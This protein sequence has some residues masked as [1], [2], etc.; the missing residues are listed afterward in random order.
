MVEDLDRAIVLSPDEPDP[1]HGTRVKLEWL[2]KFPRAVESN[3]TASKLLI[4]KYDTADAEAIPNI[5][6]SHAA[7]GSWHA[8]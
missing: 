3:V 4:A 2:R 7:L 5:G 6:N 8:A 1:Q